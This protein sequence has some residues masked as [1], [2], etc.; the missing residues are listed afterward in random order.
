MFYSVQDIKE[1]LGISLREAYQLIHSEKIALLYQI[2]V[3]DIVADGVVLGVKPSMTLLPNEYLLELI[4]KG[5]ISLELTKGNQR[6][7]ANTELNE[8]TIFIMKRD[9]DRLTNLPTIEQLQAE[10]EALKQRIE[11]LEA[12]QIADNSEPTAKSKTSINAFFMALNASYNNLDV[13]KI[14]NKSNELGNPV[15]EAVIYKYLSTG[16]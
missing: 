12:N 10:N 4:T 16:I 11:E 3:P 5:V 9:F 8:T 1:R 14:T 15:S 2:Y 7:S 6:V 13:Q